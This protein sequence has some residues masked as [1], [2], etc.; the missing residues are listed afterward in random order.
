MTKHEFHRRTQ[1][2]RRVGTAAFEDTEITKITE[3][4]EQT[5][6]TEGSRQVGTRHHGGTQVCLEL[7]PSD[8]LTGAPGIWGT[9]GGLG[10]ARSAQPPMR[11]DVASFGFVVHAVNFQP[12]ESH[13]RGN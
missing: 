11:F 10:A 12:R 7:F 9:N 8:S 1:R 5:E 13:E 3:I 2:K 6:N 4:T